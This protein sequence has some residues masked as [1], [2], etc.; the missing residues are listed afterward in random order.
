MFS[1][2]ILNCI[3]LGCLLF[4]CY[5]HNPSNTLD[6]LVPK[7]RNT[8]FLLPT[9]MNFGL[10]VHFSYIKISNYFQKLISLRMLNCSHYLERNREEI[11]KMLCQKCHGALCC[12]CKTLF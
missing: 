6:L 3:L 5:V 1:G 4:D 9:V 11:F 8:I 7:R 10:T 12:S 2:K